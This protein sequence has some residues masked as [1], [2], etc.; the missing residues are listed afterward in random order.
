MGGSRSQRHLQKHDYINLFSNNFQTPNVCQEPLKNTHLNDRDIQVQDTI[1][2]CTR[3]GYRFLHFLFIVLRIKTETN[4]KQTKKEVVTYIQ[5]LLH[6]KYYARHF[7]KKLS[8]C[9]LY[10]C[11][12]E[13]ISM[14]PIADGGK[15]YED[16][17]PPMQITT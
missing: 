14:S 3:T 15:K 6:I 5:Y 16:I 7:L 9:S 17:K 10:R 8:Y 4:Q 12:E 11:D 2:G 13:I 1:R